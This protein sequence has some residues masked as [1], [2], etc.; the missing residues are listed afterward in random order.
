MPSLQR[1]RQ[2]RLKRRNN[3]CSHAQMLRNISITV[4]DEETLLPLEPKSPTS[5]AH[6][7]I[8]PTPKDEIFTMVQLI[9]LCE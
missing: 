8:V 7:S 3:T 2:P 1:K 5:A 4:Q 9:V 6:K